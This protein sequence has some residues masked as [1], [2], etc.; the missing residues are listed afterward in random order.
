MRTAGGAGLSATRLRRLHDAMTRYVERGEVAGVAML[1][2]RH[3]EVWVDTVGRQDRDRGEPMRRDSIFRIAS[4][5]KPITA[6]AAMILV[7]EGRLG[8]DESLDEWLPELAHRRVLHRLE[9][10]LE[11]TEPA[12]RA[13]TLRDLLTFR[14]GFGTILGPSENFP[15]QQA[16]NALHI[17]GRKPMPPHTPDEW[18]RR[19]GTLPL[20]YQPGE[21]WM[22]HTGADVAGVLVA[23][24]AGQPFE[25]FLR[26]RI[27]EPLGMR[28]T[29]FHVPAAHLERFATCY[30]DNPL[31]RSLDLFDD[32]RDSQWS[33]PPAFPSGGSGLLST[34]HDYHAFARMMLY[35]G[36]LGDTRILARPTVQAMVTDQLTA[37]QKG[38][39]TAF[40]PSFWEARGWGLGM[41][42]ITRRDGPASNPGRFGWDGV[43]G[44]SWSSDPGEDLI[45]ILMIQR[46]GFAPNITGINADFWTLVYQAIED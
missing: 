2:S 3:D 36:R 18:L 27:F 32:A 1:V 22:Y 6:V 31:T 37:E 42:M 40:F 25:Q 29:G 7:E 30:Q 20:M 14:M 41:A 13:L 16:I 11:D 33:R 35:Q 45:G 43:Y 24:A 46:L 5:T 17:W 26:E 39:S 34:L 19:L 10:P 12:R 8:L 28:D 15:I 21:R 38:R 4:M 44:T 9:G 23:R